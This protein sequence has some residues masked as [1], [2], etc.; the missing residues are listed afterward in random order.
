MSK[1]SRSLSLNT[2]LKR[3]KRHV[4]RI[5]TP[6]V[7]PI[8]GPG[9]WRSVEK[10]GRELA[11]RS[12]ADL[13]VV[14]LFAWFHDAYRHDDGEDPDHGRRAAE[15]V[16]ELQGNLFHLAAETLEK[17]RYACAY[18]ADGMVSDDPTL[19]TCWDADRLDLGRVGIMP[20]PEFMST[21]A[22]K[23]MCSSQH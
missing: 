9:H 13:T 5:D 15:A 4:T 19:G 7:G 11:S 3:V 14:C 23:R 1:T 18:H 21:E 10:F 8:H 20:A 2:L 17:L 12:G 22:G 16:V 6:F